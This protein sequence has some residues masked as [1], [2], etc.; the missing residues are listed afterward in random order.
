M[1]DQS[2]PRAVAPGFV[3]AAGWILPGAGYF[4][5]G[6]VARGTTIGVTILLLFAMGMAVAGARVIEVPGFDDH[7]SA[8]YV[9]L[10]PGAD[11]Q[12][13]K[14]WIVIQEP[15]RQ[16]LDKPWFMP[17]LLAGPVALVSAKYSLYLAEP[18]A[19]GAAISRLSRSHGRLFEIGTLYT[20]VAGMLNL[21][22]I[23]DASWRASQVY[24]RSQAGSA[25]GHSNPG[26]SN[27]KSAD[28]VSA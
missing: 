28:E 21:L 7:G 23:I 14:R 27:P 13:R 4:L 10:P 5:L 12:P 18:K 19:P 8:V 24:A 9:D 1:P 25:T 3:A 2:S 6:Q 26:L 15:F 16:I 11:A 22:A 17:Q 20:A